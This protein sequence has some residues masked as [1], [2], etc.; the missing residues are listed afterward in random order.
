MRCRVCRAHTRARPRVLLHLSQW[1]ANDVPRRLALM[2]SGFDRPSTGVPPTRR[3]E[4][5]GVL[6]TEE[7]TAWFQLSLPAS[8]SDAG[9]ADRSDLRQ[10]RLRTRSFS[11]ASRP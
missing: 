8:A 10:Y 7:R 5:L 2:G 9:G 4:I 6:G 1:K 11:W 3:P